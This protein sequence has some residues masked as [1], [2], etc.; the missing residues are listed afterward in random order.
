MHF[1]FLIINFNFM[2]KTILILIIG[3]LL[4]VLIY[5]VIVSS[6]EVKRVGDIEENILESNNSK[7]L[8]YIEGSLSYP[9]EIIP[10]MYVCARNTETKYEY[11]TD[12]NILDSKY[13]YGKGYKLEVPAGNYQVAALLPRSINGNGIQEFKH[14]SNNC[15]KNDIS[16]NSILSNVVV[17]C[18]KVAEKIDI[19]GSGDFDFFKRFDMSQYYKN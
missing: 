19:L 5:T 7:C 2:K 1:T 16:C 13:T 15:E 6:K 10:N 4:I 12:Q 9:S 11:C 14:I 3:I 17:N 18:D 8:G